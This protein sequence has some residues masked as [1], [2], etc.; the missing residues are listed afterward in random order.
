[1]TARL[2]DLFFRNEYT[3][4]VAT[5]S[6]HF[7][8][9]REQPEYKMLFDAIKQCADLVGRVLHLKPHLRR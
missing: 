1:M 5:V 9:T 2:I 4:D 6:K 7:G 3:L 8:F